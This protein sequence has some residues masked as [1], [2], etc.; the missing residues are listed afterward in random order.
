MKKTFTI[1]AALALSACGLHAQATPTGASRFAP[2][3][4]V[5]GRPGRVVTLSANLYE[6]TWD[7]STRQRAWRPLPGAP[8][9]FTVDPLTAKGGLLPAGRLLTTD[10]NG[11]A[12]TRYRIP[13]KHPHPKSI[14]YGVSY[15]GDIVHSAG[16]ADVGKLRVQ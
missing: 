1:I 13:K 9:A 10:G 7:A 3:P 11:A 2:L 15:A 5:Q 16:A 6:Q 4:L 14:R 12:N 8:I